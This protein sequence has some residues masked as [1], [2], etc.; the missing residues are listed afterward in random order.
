VAER[1]GWLVG[2]LTYVVRG[3]ECE[4]L[5]LHADGRRKGVGSALI[6]EVK[7]IAR[8]GGMHPPG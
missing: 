3:T 6:A 8:R 7:Q 2:A 5:T 1:D 4:V